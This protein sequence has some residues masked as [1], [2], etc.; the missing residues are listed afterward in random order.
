MSSDH[1][2]EK[3]HDHC[4]HDHEH[5]HGHDHGHGHHHH[6]IIGNIKFAFALN[7][8]FSL[9]ELV[10]GFYIGSLAIIANSVHDFGDSVSLGAAWF[11]EGYAN[12]P[13]DSKFNFGYRRFSLLSAL[14]SGVVITTGSV[15]IMFSA[16]ARFQQAQPPSGRPMMI[17]AI[18]GLAVNGLAALRLSRGKTQNEKVL[19]WHLIEDVASWSAVFIGSIV[20]SL[21]Q[22]TWVDP[23]MAILLSAFI[24]FNVLRHLKETAYLFLQGRPAGF[25]ERKFI[26]DSLAVEGV[27]HIDH[28]AVWS[29]DGETSI[30]SARLHLHAVRDPNEIEAVKASVRSLATAMKAQATLETCMAENIPHHD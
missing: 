18:I 15:V 11:F 5:M 30:L 27:E 28:I 4:D 21:T 2:H 10:G 20:I 29:L 16:I 1:P 23:V 8:I 14:I 26:R 3:S 19:T 17:L 22:W 25:D 7:L 13:G 6:Q 12:N 9:V 24:A